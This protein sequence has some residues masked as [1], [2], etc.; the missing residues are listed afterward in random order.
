MTNESRSELSR[1]VTGFQKVSKFGVRFE[2]GSRRSGSQKRTA[3]ART[4]ASGPKPSGR[5]I[6]IGRGGLTCVVHSEG[7]LLALV[8]LLQQLER[9]AA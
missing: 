2:I 9:L 5:T 4:R 1:N 3:R 8:W 7:D 6:T